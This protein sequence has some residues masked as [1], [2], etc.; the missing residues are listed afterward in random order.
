MR[1]A[2][3]ASSNSLRHCY[4][5]I[6]QFEPNAMSLHFVIIRC[7]EWLSEIGENRYTKG[8]VNQLSV[9]LISQKLPQAF[10]FLGGI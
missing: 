5:S 4:P 2:R 10:F 1:G 8:Q 6:Q 7:T 9:I 3:L